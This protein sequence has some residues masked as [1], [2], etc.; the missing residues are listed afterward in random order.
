MTLIHFRFNDCSA[1][2]KHGSLG[3]VADGE[4]GLHAL[5]VGVG[6][7]AADEEGVALQGALND[8]GDVAPVV[9]LVQELGDVLLIH[10]LLGGRQRFVRS[11][12]HLLDSALKNKTKLRN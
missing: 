4:Q 3:L 8:R 12:S 1:H 5:D 9:E 2:L 7:A 10:L 6:L 11:H